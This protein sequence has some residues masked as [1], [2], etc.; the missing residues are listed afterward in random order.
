MSIDVRPL[1]DTERG[2]VNR[3]IF[4]DPEIYE[5]ELER[6]FARCWLF[7][8]HE[9]QISNPNDFITT[10]MGED[11]ILV[12]RDSAGNIGAFLNMCRHRGNRVCRVDRGNSKW[13]TCPYHGWT[14]DNAGRLISVPSLTEYYF[15]DLDMK[16]WGLYPVAHVDTYKGLIFATFDHE[17]PPLLEYLGD[18]AWYLDIILDRREG[19]TELIGGTHRWILEANWKVAAE[20]FAGDMYHGFPSHGSAFKVGFGE[21][22]ESVFNWQGYQIS[23]GNGHG[24]GAWEVPKGENPWSAHPA[25][26]Q[27]YIEETSSEME[28]RLGHARTQLITP[29]HGTVFPNLSLLFGTRTLRV[30]HPRGP[31]RMEICEWTIV[32][33]EASAEIK[34]ATRMHCMQRFGPTGTWEQDDMD[35]WLQT[36]GAGRGAVAK[37][38]PANYQMGIGHSRSN[39]Q[40]RGRLGHIQSDINQRALYAHWA[41]LMSAKSWNEVRV[42]TESAEVP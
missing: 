21:G 4:V 10:Y 2:L 39:S 24:L 14:Y 32:D 37:R 26:L 11:P 22:G 3:R 17:T 13:F 31:Q 16:E 19:G 27:R 8:G 6:I 34:E 18:M 1:V 20:N 30:W 23:P 28:A 33:K 36:T 38:I 35:N 29:V 41:E 25:D 40:L 5:L 15:D 42:R 9:S 7:L 12:S